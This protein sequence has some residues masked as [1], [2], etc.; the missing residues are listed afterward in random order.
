MDGEHRIDGDW[1]G[2]EQ[3]SR[4]LLPLAGR[5]FSPPR[6]P[7]YAYAYDVSNLTPALQ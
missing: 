6:V 1:D 5:G 3:T 2:L 4:F 7:V